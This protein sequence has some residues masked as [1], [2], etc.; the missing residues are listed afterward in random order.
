MAY[1]RNIKKRLLVYRLAYILVFA[2]L[3]LS[4]VFKLYY[5]IYFILVLIFIRD[6]IF[7][8]QNLAIGMGYLII[9]RYFLAGLIKSNR[10]VKLD[11]IVDLVYRDS[12][13]AS[14]TIDNETDFL[15]LDIPFWFLNSEGRKDYEKYKIEYK[16]AGKNNKTISIEL[17]IDE[18]MLLRSYCLPQ[19]AESI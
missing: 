12:G 16:V 8:I 14:N 4:C 15:L 9:K 5:F 7:P 1:S 2:G 11:D 6:F 18:V 10:K 19:S 13:V 17:S 3:I